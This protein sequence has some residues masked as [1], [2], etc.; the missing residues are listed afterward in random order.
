MKIRD[1]ITE[2][3]RRNLPPTG[4]EKANIHIDSGEAARAYDDAE[5]GSAGAVD[6]V[7]ELLAKVADMYGVEYVSDFLGLASEPSGERKTDKQMSL[8]ARS[9][10]GEK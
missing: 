8:L 9:N 3:K 10:K 6:N 2:N 7:E 1:L 4:N 5:K